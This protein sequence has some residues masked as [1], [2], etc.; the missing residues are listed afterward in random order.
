MH[1]GY[2]SFQESTEQDSFVTIRIHSSPP[3]KE[4]S[5]VPLRTI[6]PLSVLRST[7]VLISPA[8]AIGVKRPAVAIEVMNSMRA[9][10][11]FLFAFLAHWALQYLFLLSNVVKTFPQIE[12][13]F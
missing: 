4:L 9:R 2:A 13:F 6:S 8:R 12:H 1:R 7:S 5:L 3:L 10:Y 11:F